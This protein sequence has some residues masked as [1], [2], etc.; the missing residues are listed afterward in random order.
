MELWD[1]KVKVISGYYEGSEGIVKGH[2]VDNYW[3]ITPASKNSF[4]ARKEELIIL[5]STDGAK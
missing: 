1:K 2:T 4:W 5:E 3:L